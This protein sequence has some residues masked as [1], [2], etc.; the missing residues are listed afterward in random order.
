[1][2]APIAIS[3]GSDAQPSLL[4][5][6]VPLALIAALLA[7]CGEKQ[8]QAQGCSA[9]AEGDGRQADQEARHRPRRIRRPLRR[10]RLRRGAGARFRL[11]RQDPVQGRPARQG[12]AIR[13]SPSTAGRSRP[14]SR[15]RRRTLAQA[16]ANLAF[17]ESDLERGE[18][19]RARHHHHAADARPA[20]C[21]P[22]ASPRP[23]SPRRRRPCARPS[24]TSSSPS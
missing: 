20:H 3:N 10:G 9:R 12:R 22:S 8:P 15:R 21:R 16:K 17:A 7:G 11:S 1:M 5:T 18:Q 14:R 23:P 13:C 2:G 4:R 6:A 19:P 24:S